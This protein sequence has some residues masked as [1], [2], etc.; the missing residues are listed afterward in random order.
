MKKIKIPAALLVAT[1]LMLTAC[2][3]SGSSGENTPQAGQTKEAA[4]NETT[5]S[6]KD[7]T[8]GLCNLSDADEF[9]RKTCEYAEQYCKEL[10]GADVV[11]VDGRGDA[12]QQIDAVN[13]FIT[14]EVDAI[15]MI[16]V[17]PVASEP[18]LSAAT[19]A[20]IPVITMLTTFETEFP[21]Y[22]IQSDEYQ[23]GYQ[24][25]EYIAENLPEN[26]KILYLMNFLGSNSQ[27]VRAQ[28][29]HD[30]LEKLRPD[31]EILAELS[32]EQSKEVAMNTT[33]DWITAYD[34]FDAIVAQ[35]DKMALGAMEAL[36]AADRLEDVTIIGLD[37]DADC[38]L[39]IQDG[40]VAMTV[41]QDNEWIGKTAAQIAQKLINGET[42][43][44]IN[45]TPGLV[46]TSENVGEY[47]S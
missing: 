14:Q 16:T 17:D 42:A 8:I 27:V 15:I 13:N 38:L 31:I 19:D 29:L 44:E 25:A 36:K 24:Q 41:K 6:N 21:Y 18:C 22:L 35:G 26:A 9:C 20:G 2:G 33:E 1:A 28:G 12:A 11:W 43:E 47:V 45:E 40:D 37:G 34:H 7:I 10:L 30:G 23:L 32:G 3:S 46:I 39:A 5:E 4:A